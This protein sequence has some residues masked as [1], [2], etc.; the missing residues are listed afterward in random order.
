MKKLWKTLFAALLVLPMFTG[1][2]AG[3]PV[4]ADDATTANVTINKR[5]W[6]D[7]TAPAQGSVA[8]TGEAMTD[9][10]GEALEGAGF[11][12]YDVTNAYL[13]L[14]AGG[15]TQTEAVKEIS[16]NAANY[17]TTVAKAEQT[18]NAEGQTTFSGL[19]LKDANGNDKVY[20][21][22]ETS[23]PTDVSVTEK[24]TPIV[25]AMPI[26]TVDANGDFTNTLNTNIQVYPKNES[27][28]DKKEVTNR[29]DFDLVTNNGETYRNVTTGDILNFKL[30]LNIPADLA[31]VSSYSVTD[32]P[33]DGLA[34]VDGTI[35]VAGLT[36][37][38]DYKVTKNGNGFMLELIN[39]GTAEAPVYTDTVLAL[40][41]KALTVTYSMKLTATI[42]PD[43]L[44]NNSAVVNVGGTDHEAL[45]PTEPDVP[46]NPP[47]KFGTGGKKFVKKDSQSNKTLAGAKFVVKNAE[48][49]Y[50]KFDV[51]AAEKTATEY[52]FTEWVDTQAEADEV[53]SD[54]NGQFWIKGLTNGDYQ[55][56]ETKAPSDK[57]V[58]LD[59]DITFT[60]THGDYGTQELTTVKNTPKGLLPSTGGK[61]IA[62]FLIV[63]AGMM[64]AAYIWFKKSKAQ[65][66]V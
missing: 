18:T 64:A 41:G 38:K 33:T 46:G 45:V 61:G 59:K 31:K 4:N 62:A 53:T 35:D 8:N 28:Q 51:N 37:D 29:E 32:T 60:V 66:E 22:V 48:G 54:S 23:T 39:S 27:Q 43:Q 7:G 26:Y 52:V 14:I 36:V 17:T 20:M 57:Y 58:V 1:L 47:V 25:L 3:K 15:K 56:H 44:Q 6:K 12:A 55:L 63:G 50:A 34:Y 5:I 13:A 40:A 24:A 30:T 49:K 21:L 65:A 42:D 11:T 16:D 9:F 19:A 10:G 2:F